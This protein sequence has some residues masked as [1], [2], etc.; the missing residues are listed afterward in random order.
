MLLSWVLKLEP[1]EP[2]TVPANLC[3]AAHAWF[4]GRVRTADPALAEE[5][6]G[7]QGLRPFTVSNLWELGRERGPEVT[8]SP[9]RGYTLRVTSF[10]PRLSELLVGEVIPGV[11]ETLALLDG[12]LRVTGSTLD[13]AEHR[14]GGTRPRQAT[15]VDT[16]AHRKRATPTYLCSSV[17]ICGSYPASS[18]IRRPTTNT[19]TPATWIR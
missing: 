13:P 11:P 1:Q 14:A 16:C 7:G 2:A 12:S 6:H 18:A 10:S 19:I 5:L 8:L 15:V 3:R 4:L 9:G 17:F